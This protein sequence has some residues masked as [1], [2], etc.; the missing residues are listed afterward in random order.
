[1]KPTPAGSS[2][3]LS[4]VEGCM[5]MIVSKGG[6]DVHKTWLDGDLACS[7]CHSIKL[8]AS[9][10][11]AGCL[12]HTPTTDETFRCMSFSKVHRVHS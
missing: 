11:A 5:V 4:Q 3:G 6:V 10:V 12:R 1:M 2:Q 7:S 9:T 8:L